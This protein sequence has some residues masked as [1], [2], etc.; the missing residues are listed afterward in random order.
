MERRGRVLAMLT[1]LKQICNHPAHYLREPDDS[2]PR[3]SGK[4][5]RFLELVEAVADRGDPLVFTQYRE[6][7]ELLE[8]VLSGRLGTP[9]PFLHGGL[10]RIARDQMVA[11]FQDGRDRPCSSC[12]SRRAAPG[13]T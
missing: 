6:M 4:L 12:R 10:P 2:T 1:A 5:M 7:G 11:M 8:H 13:S 9:I 3:R